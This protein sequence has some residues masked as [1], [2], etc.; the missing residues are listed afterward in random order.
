MQPARLLLVRE[1]IVSRADI[2]IKAFSITKDFHPSVILTSVR[3]QKTFFD[4][5]IVI[6]GPL[7]FPAQVQTL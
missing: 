4:Q 2:S 6:S 5:T 3:L 1:A 7:D